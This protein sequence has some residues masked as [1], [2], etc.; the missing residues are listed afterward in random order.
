MLIPSTTFEYPGTIFLI[1]LEGAVSAA[2]SI[3]S[4]LENLFNIS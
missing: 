4:G 3:S 1:R 2:S